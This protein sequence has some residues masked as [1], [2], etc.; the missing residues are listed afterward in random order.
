MALTDEK[1]HLLLP[2]DPKNSATFS[3]AAV[4]GQP[5]SKLFETLACSLEQ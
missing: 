4:A 2:S 3:Q 1:C 5:V